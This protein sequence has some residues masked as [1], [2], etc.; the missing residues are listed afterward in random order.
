MAATYEPITTTTVGSA[1]T[2]VTLS[3]ISASYTDLIVIISNIKCSTA[4]TIYMR[5][6]GDT[7][8]NY[9][10]TWLAGNGSSASSSRQTNSSLG[11]LTGAYNTGLSSTNPSQAI[12]QINN[13][14]NTTTYKSTLSRYGLGTVE[15]EAIAGL[16]RSTSAINSLTFRVNS[17]GFA[18]GTT[19]TLYGI[20]AA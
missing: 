14:S 10:S 6:N 17:G 20:L 4:E 16:W 11:V 3:S 18:T 7:G 5:I 12:M 1:T 2:A 19:F 13:Y 9:S 8:T 15:V